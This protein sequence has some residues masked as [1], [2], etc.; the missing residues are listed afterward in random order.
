[1]RA[2]SSRA[3]PSP[4]TVEL[5]PIQGMCDEAAECLEIRYG[6]AYAYDHG[7]GCD[8][9]FGDH[10]GD[11]EFFA[12]LVKRDT[13]WPDARLTLSAWKMIRDFTAA[14]WNA[15]GDSSK[16]GAYSSCP[17][18]C[19]SLSKTE[20][21]A[22]PSQCN[23]GG[24]C[25][26][27]S[28]CGGYSSESSCNVTGACQWVHTCTEKESRSCYSSSP[29]TGH[30]TYYAAESKHGLYHSDGECDNGAYYC[31]NCAGNSY[32]MRNEKGQLLQ[33]VGNIWDNDLMD[34][35]IADPDGCGVYDVWSGQSFG[36]ASDYRSHFTATIPW[37]V[38]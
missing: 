33:N 32:D 29:Q 31:D 9:G 13:S 4:H 38:H 6:I 35:T 10:V 18:S 20:C 25:T 30:R 3:T 19:Y 8:L 12:V 36:D 28:F 1:V 7:D 15:L 16:V 37:A 5:L 27:L 14:H 22:R 24:Y 11:S 17:T 23:S 2:T 26:G 34:T 21:Q